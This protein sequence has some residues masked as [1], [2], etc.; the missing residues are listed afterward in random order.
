MD[1]ERKKSTINKKT[2]RIRDNINTTYVELF[3][4]SHPGQETLL[5]SYFTSMPNC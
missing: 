4:S 2:V 5:I 1:F 3:K